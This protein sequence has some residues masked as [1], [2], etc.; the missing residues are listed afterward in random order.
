MTHRL[1]KRR[2]SCRSHQLSSRWYVCIRKKPICVNSTHY[3]PSPNPAS[4]TLHT[5]F[6]RPFQARP[7]G[8]RYIILCGWTS[9]RMPT[10]NPHPTL[11]LSR[12]P[13]SR[14]C[15]VR[16]TLCKR[17]HK[18]SK[19][20]NLAHLPPDLTPSRPSLTPKEEEEEEEEKEKKPMFYIQEKISSSHIVKMGNH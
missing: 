18:R 19:C 17:R 9:P 3:P 10:L 6:G 13:D 15:L 4:P 7:D 12:T 1:R 14:R 20:S 5:A 16:N 2:I 8:G 11:C